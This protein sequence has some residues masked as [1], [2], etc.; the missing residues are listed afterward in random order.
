MTPGTNTCSAWSGST[1]WC[2]QRGVPFRE[3]YRQVGK[4]I[5]DGAYRPNRE[6]HHTHEGS[7]G[8]LC[9][10][11]ITAQMEGVLAGFGFGRA[12]IGRVNVK[13]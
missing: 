8:N 7:I 9:N 13:F 10:D 1:N 6:V 11:Q 4:E 3:A 5:A 2:F 12:A